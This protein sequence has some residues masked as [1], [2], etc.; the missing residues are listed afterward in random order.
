MMLL[1]GVVSIE[2]TRRVH[3]TAVSGQGG[4][5]MREA[6]VDVD[7]LASGFKALVKKNMALTEENKALTEQVEMLKKG[8]GVLVELASEGKA[9]GKG[10][11][12]QEVL[13]EVELT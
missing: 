10:E 8:L 6:G 3:T 11:D 12:A 5:V 4:F 9:E 7:R 13:E 2:A 1:A